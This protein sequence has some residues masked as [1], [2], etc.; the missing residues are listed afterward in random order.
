MEL[1]AL[2]SLDAVDMRERGGDL[3]L[4]GFLMYKCMCA[5]AFSF[6]ERLP[7]FCFHKNYFLNF[8]FFDAG[9]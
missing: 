2:R 8:F 9:D 5:H 7:I 4:W 1:L 3:G 6:L